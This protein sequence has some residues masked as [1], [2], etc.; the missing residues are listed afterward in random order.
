MKTLIATLA[1]LISLSCGAAEVML[2]NN[3]DRSIRFQ[4]T[5][6]GYNNPQI[7]ILGKKV[8]NYS[9]YIHVISSPNNININIASFS[10]GEY[11]WGS[12]VFD[13]IPISSNGGW[14]RICGLSGQPCGECIITLE[15]SGDNVVANYGE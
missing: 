11:D 3:T 12:E 5:Y 6:E 8:E 10:T 7:N 4:M 1:T 15:R 13:P 2:I 14:H 9:S